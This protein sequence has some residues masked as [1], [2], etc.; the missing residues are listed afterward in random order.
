ML[1]AKLWVGQLH[2]KEGFDACFCNS[3]PRKQT[4]YYADRDHHY[5]E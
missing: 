4:C 5:N 3:V 2:H 1:H